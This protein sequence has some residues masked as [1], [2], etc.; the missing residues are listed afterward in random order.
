MTIQALTAYDVPILSKSFGDRVEAVVWAETEGK[1]TF[2]GLR[3]VQ[4]TQRNGK[5]LK[6][7]IWKDECVGRAA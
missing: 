6:L 5:P 4:L 2:P 3:V 7:T 1:H